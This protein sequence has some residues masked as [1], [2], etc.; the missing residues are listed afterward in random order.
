VPTS[1]KEEPLPIHTMLNIALFS[2]F[3]L[4]TANAQTVAPSAVCE[5]WLRRVESIAV[6]HRYQVESSKRG[7]S[8][9]SRRGSRM[10]AQCKRRHA[11]LHVIDASGASTSLEFTGAPGEPLFALELTG[12][13]PGVGEVSQT[14]V[15]EARGPELKGFM[16]FTASAAGDFVSVE[17]AADGRTLSGVG[18]ADRA[19]ARFA[20]V[21]RASVAWRDANAFLYGLGGMWNP[22][23]TPM[24][25]S[26]QAAFDPLISIA[27]PTPHAAETDQDALHTKRTCGASGAACAAALFFPP[28]VAACIAGT[29]ACLAATACILADCAGD[30]E[31]ATN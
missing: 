17:F 26:E 24:K 11:E 4:F 22:L 14:H 8:G 19:N 21:L 10:H 15:F 7:L 23:Q 31:P 9:Q 1:R 20:P 16:T 3:S 29:A 13:F 12:V 25:A 6:L 27:I 2:M 30:D 5:Q 28:A 18:D